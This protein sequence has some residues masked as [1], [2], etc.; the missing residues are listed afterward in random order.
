MKVS[1][2]YFQ[3]KD[4]TITFYIGQNANDNF[5]IL[6]N[7]NPSDLWFHI[8]DISSCHVIANIP[9]DFIKDKKFIKQ[10]V[11]TGALLCK[12]NT[13]KMRSMNN[14]EVIYTEVENVEKT[15]IMGT[16]I[17]LKTKTVCC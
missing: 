6:D 11:N 13:S 14:V 12:T 7:A 3:K 15:N 10:I 4:I 16:V 5:L 9:Q 2:I 1:E 17:A 8:K